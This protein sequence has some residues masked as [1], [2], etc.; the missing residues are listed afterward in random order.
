MYWW[1][2]FILIATFFVMEFMAWATHKFVMHGFMWKFHED[3]HVEEPGFLKK[4]TCFFLFTQSLLG[5]V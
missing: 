2:P 1:G 5:Y 4:M 3:H